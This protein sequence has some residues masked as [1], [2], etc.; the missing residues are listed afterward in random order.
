MINNI[1]N[2][3]IIFL[4]VFFSAVTVFAKGETS[5]NNGG[6]GHADD[7]SKLLTGRGYYSHSG[8]QKFF[9][10]LKG[11]TYVIYLTV[12]STWYNEENET[13]HDNVNKNIAYLKD[14]ANNLKIN[15]IPNIK[16]FLT[17]NGN[18]HGEY[19]HLGWDHPS[20]APDTMRKWLVRKEILRDFLGN[21][22]SFGLNDRTD[23][24]KPSKR[25]SL[26]ALFYYV[27]ILGDHENNTITTARSRIPIKSLDEQ[28][29][30][31]A[32]IITQWD[33]N[34]NNNNG[35]PATTI[36]QELNKHFSILFNDQKNSQF[37]KNLQSINNFLPDVYEINYSDEK[38]VRQGKIQENQR[39]R[40]KWILDILFNNVP[41]LL[42]NESF[43]VNFY[44]E[45]QK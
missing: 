39:A 22:F 2:S 27:H 10:F 44:K 1:R 37:Y 16:E 23:F 4:L 38:K 19:S 7:I 5:D 25:E 42:K 26:A 13:P 8:N 17:P 30:E 3:V 34:N 20:Y 33:I 14:P 41:Y 28:D 40:A 11:L 45:M 9:K 6:A 15:Y 29:D 18:F 32:G 43:A 24:I 21:Y 35:I 12:D 36:I 31:D